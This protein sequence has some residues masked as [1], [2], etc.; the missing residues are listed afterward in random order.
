MLTQAIVTAGAMFGWGI[1]NEAAD[2]Q[3][4]LANIV[5]IEP[6]GGCGKAWSFQSRLLRHVSECSVAIVLVQNA[7]TV[8]GDKDIGPAIIIV[9]THRDAHAERASFNTSGCGDVGKCA[10]AIVFV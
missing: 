1:V 9:I 5:V 10:I 2:E 7:F 6:D 4:E 3:I 8:G